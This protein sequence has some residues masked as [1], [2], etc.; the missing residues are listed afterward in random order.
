MLTL[1][2]ILC[3]V[4]FSDASRRALR[5]AL[6][7]A[8]WHG[9]EITVLHVEDVLLYAASVD[10]AAYP[11]IGH[12]HRE[13]LHAFVV[14][15]GGLDRSVT[16]AIVTGS[17]VARILD[18]AAR[19]ASDLI[20]MGTNGRSGL[21]RAV[22]G[23]VTERV[24]RLSPVPVLAIPP[25]ASACELDQVLPF[26]P[27]VCASDFSPACRQALDLAIVM[28]QEADARLL[29]VH[30]RQAADADSGA[31]A[32][33]RADALRFEPREWRTAPLGRLRRGLPP[34]AVFRCRPEPVVVDG[35]PADALLDIADR[36]DAKLIVMGVQTR[37]ALD[38]LI[39]GSTTRRV[40]QAA[41]CP[42]LTIRAGRDAAPWPAWPPARVPQLREA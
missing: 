19:N 31:A 29:V 35:R 13:D 6:A 7:I 1:D 40:L 11:D 39:F 38:R 15:A 2:R 30:A 24:V 37:G 28:G 9:S 33:P 21:A 4:D 23:S 3:P 36:E 32:R 26:D 17:P 41:A 12:T 16:A 10:A 5:Y 34:D 8:R 20:V 14:E 25:S 42:V 18:H 22:L 27:I